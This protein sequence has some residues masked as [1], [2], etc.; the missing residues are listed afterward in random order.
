VRTGYQGSPNSILKKGFS[1][2][3]PKKHP[4]DE[5]MEDIWRRMLRALQ[6]SIARHAGQLVALVS[7]A[8]P[9]TVMRVGL[10][11]RPLTAASLHGVV[12]PARASV[13]EIVA[14]PDRPHTVTYFNVADVEE[15]KL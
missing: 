1:F 3:E 14:Y 7:H 12:F 8:D 13:T 9:I 2:Y 6:R 4:D 5:S 10:E 15:V 11:A